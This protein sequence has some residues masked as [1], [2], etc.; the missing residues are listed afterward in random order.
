MEQYFKFT[1]IYKSNKLIFDFKIYLQRWLRI[2]IA[3]A[4]ILAG[5]MLPVNNKSQFAS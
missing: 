3:C 1:F 4:T 2:S 5:R